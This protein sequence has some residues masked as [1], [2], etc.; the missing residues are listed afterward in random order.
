MKKNKY[1]KQKNK[2][3]IVKDKFQLPYN[4]SKYPVQE[5]KK[6]KNF[7]TQSEIVNSIVVGDCFEVMKKID[8]NT[9]DMIFADP[10]YNMQLQN[11]LYRI[12]IEVKVYLMNF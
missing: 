7:Q 8:N 1:I 2:I 6:V 12:F 9:F 4:V 3:D 10:P 11:E 5:I